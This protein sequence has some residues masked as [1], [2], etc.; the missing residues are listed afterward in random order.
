MYLPVY[1]QIRSSLAYALQDLLMLTHRYLLLVSYF[2][3]LI[4]LANLIIL[5]WFRFCFYLTLLHISSQNVSTNASYPLLHA[6]YWWTIIYCPSNL[7]MGINFLNCHVGQLLVVEYK[8]PI[9]SCREN[10]TLNYLVKIRGLVLGSF[11]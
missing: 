1:I 3:L 4:P 9:Y 2:I 5:Y 11:G 7:N 8:I 10:F 6:I